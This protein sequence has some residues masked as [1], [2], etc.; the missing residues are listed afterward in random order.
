M[1]GAGKTTAKRRKKSKTSGKTPS[2]KKK[3]GRATGAPKRGYTAAAAPAD[4]RKRVLRIIAALKREFP[5]ARC[6]LEFSTP[7]ELLVATILSAQC[8]D[9]RVNL[10]TKDLFRDFRSARDYADSPVETLE[11]AVR[12][13]GFYRNKTKSIREATRAIADDFNGEVPATMEQLLTLP[14]VG[15]KTANCVLGNAFGVPGIVV[16]THMLRLSRRMGL[17]AQTDPDKVE[18]DLMEIV[19]REDWTVFSHL[20]TSLGRSWCKAR[21]PACETCPVADECPKLPYK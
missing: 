19:P 15:R 16:D 3:T 13:T 10:V 1:P 12:S 14:G 17:T 20:I 2:A 9:A 4:T 8:T 21:N 18:V 5:D 6:A 11:E 7:L